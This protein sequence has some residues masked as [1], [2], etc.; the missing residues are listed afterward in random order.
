MVSPDRPHLTL[1]LAVDLLTRLIA[2]AK[3]AGD[4]HRGGG[5]ITFE[6]PTD[7]KHQFKN[8]PGD[9]QPNGIICDQVRVTLDS[10]DL[11]VEGVV[12]P[13]GI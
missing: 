13:F 11:E 2:A 7:P 10:S 9:Q 12:M 6:I 8:Q 3:L 1:T 4:K 5:L